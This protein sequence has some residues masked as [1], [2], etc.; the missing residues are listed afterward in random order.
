MA[1]HSLGPATILA[2]LAATPI[3]SGHR[4]SEIFAPTPSSALPPHS[5]AEKSSDLCRSTKLSN[6][7]L[8][9]N[10]KPRDAPPGAPDFLSDK[11]PATPSANRRTLLCAFQRHPKK[12]APHTTS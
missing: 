10:L 1:N 9:P 2:L 5:S 3:S 8:R 11:S 12:S 7:L 6:N 4:R